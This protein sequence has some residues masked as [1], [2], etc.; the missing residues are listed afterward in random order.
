[1]VPGVSTR[2]PSTPLA[3]GQCMLSQTPDPS[4]GAVIPAI[5]QHNVRAALRWKPQGERSP[6][7]DSPR[8][9]RKLI[10]PRQGFEYSR[11]G[12]PNRGARYHR[13]NPG[14]HMLSP[15]P[16]VL[17]QLPRFLSPSVTT[18]TS[19]ASTMSMVALSVT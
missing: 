16:R 7:R 3:R 18:H 17:P 4:T 8:F 2:R 19:S 14:V 5:S 13:L 1:M 15:L 11:L 6:L 10:L 12:I 9:L